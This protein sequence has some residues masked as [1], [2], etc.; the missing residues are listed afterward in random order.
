MDK[1]VEEIL[2]NL[3]K[4]V[5]VLEESKAPEP[6]HE[7]PKK[8]HWLASQSQ[9]DYVKSLGGIPRKNMTKKQ[10][11]ELID[12]LKNDKIN[13]LN[14]N[15]IKTKEDAEKRANEE[16]DKA[17]DQEMYP[18]SKKLTKKEIEKLEEEGALL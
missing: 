14:D 8:N 18:R 2:T 5:E 16:L 15:E 3:I 4:R 9:I 6:T 12:E 10:A 11:A 1:I 7:K 17:K 13:L